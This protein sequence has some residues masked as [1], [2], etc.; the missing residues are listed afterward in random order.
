MPGLDRR[1]AHSNVFVCPGATRPSAHVFV[2]AVTPPRGPSSTIHTGRFGSARPACSERREN[3]VDGHARRSGSRG[4]AVLRTRMRMRLL[5][6][7]ALAA[8]ELGVDDLDGPRA[9]R[10]VGVLALRSPPPQPATQRGT[11]RERDPATLLMSG[12]KRI[13]AAC[14]CAPHRRVR[15]RF[16]FVTPLGH[17]VRSVTVRGRACALPAVH[18]E[19]RGEGWSEASP[20]AGSSR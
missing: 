6:G 12:A 14:A 13:R 8:R 5:L 4:R 17:C 3:A 1:D 7:E 15:R 2:Y 18:E 16:P 20:I 19:R 10:L 9:R 11:R